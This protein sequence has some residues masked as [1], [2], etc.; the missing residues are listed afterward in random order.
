MKKLLQMEYPQFAT[1]FVSITKHDGLPLNARWVNES[2][3]AKEQSH[4]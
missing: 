4:D 2:I 1:K 3:Q